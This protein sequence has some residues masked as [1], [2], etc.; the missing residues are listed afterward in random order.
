MRNI[1]EAGLA[2]LATKLGNEPICLVEIDWVDGG[3]AAY[4]DRTVGSIPGRIVE[5]GDLDD[6]SSLS[7]SGST[8]Q[9]TVKLDDTD[10]TIKTIFDSHDPH[11]RPARVYQYFDGLDLADKFLLFSGVLMSPI[12]WNERDRTVTVTI[13]SQLEDQECG[14]TTDEYFS[15][16]IPSSI[17]NDAWPMIFGTVADNKAVQLQPPIIGTTL[18]PVGVLAGEELMLNSPDDPGVDFTLSTHKANCQ[19]DFLTTLVS[20]FDLAAQNASDAVV[21]ASYAKTRDGYTAQIAAIKLQIIQQLVAFE[22]TRQCT[23]NQR[24]VKINEA[25]LLGYGTNPLRIMGGENFP[26]G[27]VTANINGA[28]F[29]GTMAGDMLTIESRSSDYL[30][31]IAQGILNN[32]TNGLSVDPAPVTV[33]MPQA[34]GSTVATTYFCKNH[35]TVKQTWTWSAQV[36]DGYDGKKWTTYTSQQYTCSVTGNEDIHNYDTI[37][38]HL[39]IDAGASVQLINSDSLVYVAS[40]T[41]GTVTAVKALCNVSGVQLLVDVPSYTTK[42]ISVNGIDATAIVLPQMLSTILGEHWSDNLYVSFKSSIGPKV[43]DILQWIVSTFSDLTCD[44]TSFA[45]CQVPYNANFAI[46]SSRNVLNVLQDIAFQ[47]CC[48]LWIVDRVV[49]IKYLPAK[50]EAVD[51]FTESDIDAESGIEVSLTTTEDLVTKMTIN[52]SELPVPDLEAVNERVWNGLT[53]VN[54]LVTGNDSGEL[55]HPSYSQILR[56]NMDRYGQHDASFNFYIY[57]DRASVESCANFWLSRK[58]NTWKRI[59]F[60]TPLHKLN[61]ETFDAVTLNFAHPYVASLPVLAIITSA[62]YDSANNCIHFECE[63]PVLAGTAKDCGFYWEQ[64]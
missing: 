22:A 10:G 35:E 51:T 19:I 14:I 18:N 6:A 62:K 39:W 27:P 12:A 9:L 31:Q 34:D 52:W 28:I 58:S 23:L 59:R 7:G 17:P 61:L 26:Q 25:R 41:P 32:I 15:G 3:T 45:A 43:T 20:K 4:A 57:N 55:K 21:A 24:Q 33:Q 48:R 16:A 1:S 40:I 8:A 30:T 64:Q 50:P 29:I 44:P 36:P 47:A 54:K 60:T 42:T 37:L 49:Y 5:L 63:T 2:K 46:N 56:N 53:Y 11:K 13:V 38:Q